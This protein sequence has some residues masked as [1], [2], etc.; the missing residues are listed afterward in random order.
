V[1]AAQQTY[2]L[3]STIIIVK[4]R[5]YQTATQLSA[6]SFHEKS[7]GQSLDRY[8]S[9]EISSRGRTKKQ[10]RQKDTKEIS[11]RIKKKS[12]SHGEKTKQTAKSKL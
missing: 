12:K 7:R 6:S 10:N 5:G 9:T 4:K 8:H 2:L 11:V 3:L 1:P